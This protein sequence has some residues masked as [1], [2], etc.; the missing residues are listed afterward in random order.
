MTTVAVALTSRSNVK[1]KIF[2]VP[3]VP[4][5]LWGLRDQFFFDFFVGPERP[6]IFFV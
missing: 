3:V 5:S 4:E 2:G 6:D 1:T